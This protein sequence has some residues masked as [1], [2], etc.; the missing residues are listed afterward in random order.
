MKLLS[1]SL[2]ISPKMQ[3]FL[4]LDFRN[5]F[6]NHEVPKTKLSRRFNERNNFILPQFM[7]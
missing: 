5:T 1:N 2:I 4:K 3:Y 7:N 6:I